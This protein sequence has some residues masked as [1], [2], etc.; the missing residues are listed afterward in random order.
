MTNEWTFQPTARPRTEGMRRSLEDRIA[1][2]G[3]TPIFGGLPKSHLK[4]LAKESGHQRFPAGKALVTE[5]QVGSVF[6]AIVDGTAKVTRGGRTVKRLGPGDFFGEMSILTRSPRS[7][8]VTVES[9]LECVT[10]P[11]S[12]LRSVLL[13]EP[14]ICFSMLTTM[15]ERLE[16]TDRRI[17]A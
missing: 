7:A 17:I 15:A 1:A 9:S 10:L 11:A 5:G 14:T 4:A 16:E 3:R 13:A 8:T 6:Y 2:L 12:G